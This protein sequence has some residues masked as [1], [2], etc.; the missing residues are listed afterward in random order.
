[1]RRMK[2]ILWITSLLYTMQALAAQS[3]YCPKH[4]GYINLGMSAGEVLAACGE[5]LMKNNQNKPV[6]Q[7]IPVTQLIYTSLN[8]GATY[9]GWNSIYQTWSL[10][11]GST[12]VTLQIDIVN[13]KIASVMMNGNNTNATTLCNNGSLKIGDDQSM[14]YMACGSPDLINQTYVDQVVP[15]TQKPEVWIYQVDP[16]QPSYRLTFI[17]GTLQSID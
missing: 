4:Q 2:K 7:R 1:M 17:N 3:F 11:S 6:T 13:Q 9:Q 10:P 16:Y 5:P 12:G 15:S 14:A 8:S